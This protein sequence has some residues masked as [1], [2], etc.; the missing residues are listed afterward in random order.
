MGQMQNEHC[1]EI[2]LK[3]QQQLALEREEQIYLNIGSER[4]LGKSEMGHYLHN[5]FYC[6]QAPFGIPNVLH[7]CHS[8]S[9]HPFS[10]P[11]FFS[12][13]YQS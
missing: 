2:F 3:E 10:L 6:L 5:M 8:S 13:L 11:T 7:I 1:T 9:Y 12:S 4:E